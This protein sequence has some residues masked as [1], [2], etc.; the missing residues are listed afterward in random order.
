MKIQLTWEISTH[1]KGDNSILLC[2][3]SI[4]GICYFES[5]SQKLMCFKQVTRFRVKQFTQG[6][7]AKLSDATYQELSKFLFYS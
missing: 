3:P 1:R 4:N 5:F 6:L 2:Q 7:K